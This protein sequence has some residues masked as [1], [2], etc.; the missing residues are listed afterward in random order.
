MLRADR[1]AFVEIAR[2]RNG[3]MKARAA[4]TLPLERELEEVHKNT[5]V[6][7]FLLPTPGK[8]DF[9]FFF[10]RPFCVCLSAVPVQVV[11]PISRAATADGGQG[12]ARPRSRRGKD[13]N[14][15]RDED[16]EHTRMTSS[17]L[18]VHILAEGSRQ[19]PWCVTPGSG[20]GIKSP[21]P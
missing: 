4:G 7:Y 15:K 16:D 17:R 20:P 19:E 10:S 1:Q 3:A 2:N 18:K 14:R 21:L 5:E 6:V 13:N 12:G 11:S 8:K 9:V